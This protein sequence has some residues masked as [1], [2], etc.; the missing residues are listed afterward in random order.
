MDS[1]PPTLYSKVVRW[2]LQ[3]S[4]FNVHVVYRTGIKQ[5]AADALLR[6]K[7]TGTIETPIK[8]EILVLY[9]TTSCHEKE[10]AKVMN[11]QDFEVLNDKKGYCVAC[12]I[13]NC[14]IERH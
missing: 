8:E 13:R 10:E 9:I 14:D 12:C 1:E 4:E 2:R 11:M 5:Q 7:T 3:L 6:R